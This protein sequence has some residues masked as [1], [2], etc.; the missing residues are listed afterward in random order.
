MP[1]YSNDPRT[2]QARF[3]GTCNKCGERYAKGARVFYYP[4]G[5]STY[6]GECAEAAA[7]EF[8]AYVWNED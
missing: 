3:D 5:K 8:A 2:I 1:R 6:S 4:I 7:R